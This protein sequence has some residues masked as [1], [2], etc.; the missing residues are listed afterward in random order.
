MFDRFS[1]LF[2]M[3]PMQRLFRKGHLWMAL[4]PCDRT[5]FLQAFL[6][7]PIVSCCLSLR[8]LQQ[9][10]CWLDWLTARCPIRPPTELSQL[11]HIAQIVNLAARSSIWGNCLKR[12]LVLWFLLR[13]QGVKTTVRIG[14]QREHGTFCAHAWIEYEELVL[15]DRPDVHQQFSAFSKSL[16]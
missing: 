15:N 6:L 9:T 16:S 11:Q 7:L 3:I 1:N 12:S 5:L 14:V 4:P 8:G 10:Q 13:C 2:V